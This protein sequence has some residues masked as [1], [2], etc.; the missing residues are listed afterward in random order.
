MAGRF[1]LYID[2]DV[3]GRVVK[4]LEAAGWDV[5]RG[6]DAFPEKTPDLTHFVRAAQDARVLVSND[7]DMLVLAEQS[8]VQGKSLAGLVWWPRSH[9][10]RMSP[11]DF[12]EAFEVLSRQDDPFASYPIVHVKLAR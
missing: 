5:L 10:R 9:Y 12:R 6:I 3:D 2:A 1:P 11:G 7:T 8:F 4:A